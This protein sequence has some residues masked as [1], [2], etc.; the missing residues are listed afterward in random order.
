MSGRDCAGC[1]QDGAE[2]LMNAITSDIHAAQADTQELWTDPRSRADAQPDRRAEVQLR[3]L[4]ADAY[5][6]D[7]RTNT[8]LQEVFRGVF[9]IDD[10][11]GRG[12]LE[13]VN[14]ELEEPKYDVEECIQRG[15][16]YAAPLKVILRLI[17][18]DV[19]E[20]TG[21]RSIRDIKEQPVYMGDMPLMTDNGTFIINGTER[22]IVSQMHRSPGVFFDHDKGKTHSQRQVPVRRARHSLSRLLAGFRVRQQGHGLCPHRPEAEAAGHDTALCAGERCRASRIA[23]SASQQVRIRTRSISAAWMPKPILN[24]FYGQ[25]VFT[26][27]PR[28][29]RVRSTPM[30]SVA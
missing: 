24:Y 20:D 27:T 22:V 8:G 23:P 29:G 4:P 16:N 28:A 21:A 26:L 18:W 10:F 14:Y 3:G 17:V 15:M 12:R 13:F 9:P 19:D 11:A 7:S 30:R 25:V 2:D 1:R 5:A 6:P